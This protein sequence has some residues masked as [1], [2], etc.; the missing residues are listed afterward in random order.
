M[1]QADSSGPASGQARRGEESVS[2]RSAKR[3]RTSASPVLAVAASPPPPPPAAA[4]AA[5]RSFSPSSSPSPLGLLDVSGPPI[6]L[7]MSYLDS[8]SLY[9]LGC[10]TSPAL[11]PC[12]TMRHA[13]NSAAAGGGYGRRSLAR[14][15]ALVD[16]GLIRT[17]SV[18][19]LLR[20]LN[21]R[22][23]EL[24]DRCLGR[25][26]RGGREVDASAASAS[27]SAAAAALGPPSRVN[28]IRQDFGLFVCGQC[29][30]SSRL[31][32]HGH[33]GGQEAQAEQVQPSAAPG[34]GGAGARPASSSPSSSSPSSAAA[35]A[36][37]VLIRPNVGSLELAQEAL[38][39]HPRT[40]LVRTARGDPCVWSRMF[41]DSAGEPAGPVLTAE[42]LRCLEE[43][44]RRDLPPD[45]HFSV[46]AARLLDALADKRW[47]E[48]EKEEGGEGKARTSSR[49]AEIVALGA[50]AE[51]EL[52]RRGTDR[53]FAALRKRA[54]LCRRRVG[55]FE[56]LLPYM[57][58]ALRGRA[59]RDLALTYDPHPNPSAYKNNEPCVVFR[60]PL[61]QSCLRL[62]TVCPSK[63]NE[64]KIVGATNELRE[65]FDLAWEVGFPDFAFLLDPERGNTGDRILCRALHRYY[66]PRVTPSDLFHHE[67]ADAALFGLIREGRSVEALY[68]RFETPSARRIRLGPLASG[69]VQ[70]M[71]WNMQLF[72]LDAA[73]SRLGNGGFGF[74]QVAPSDARSM[75]KDMYLQE[76]KANNYYIYRCE[77][78][79]F[80][81]DLALFFST[82]LLRF[83]QSMAKAR[84]YCEEIMEGTYGEGTSDTEDRRRKRKRFL[85][86]AVTLS[87]FSNMTFDQ[88]RSTM[89]FLFNTMEF[90]G[91]M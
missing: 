71:E 23:C 55:Q 66:S 61:V 7:I 72:F 80:V 2:A 32:A 73:L 76:A 1:S 31:R 11:V 42:D 18:P 43:L 8:R 85:R 79:G 77:G 39:A 62:Y 4:A 14:L 64:I 25:R 91:E 46:L 3:A 65:P 70:T 60:N 28:L 30:D 45:T 5:I 82:Y 88:L 22:W 44:A 59:W 50:E 38:L 9:R 53:A 48:S 78:P 68:R 63:G 16:G 75:A 34:P 36:V 89:L 12:V 56:A 13:V 10:L 90:G 47:A 52:L 26:R 49:A 35:A 19:R 40:T 33:E 81:E 87:N 58:G 21:G 74:G 27:A 29:A 83:E 37:T 67:R 20:L 24:G 86:Q 15:A 17:P 69:S 57:R 54:D 41:V 84:K 51:K 6:D